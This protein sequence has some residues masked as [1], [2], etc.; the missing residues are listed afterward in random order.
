MTKH[1]ASNVPVAMWG[2]GFYAAGRVGCHHNLKL[3][4]TLR[5]EHNSNPVCQFNCFANFTGDFSTLASVTNANPGSVPYSS[6]IAS[7]LH[8][9]YPGTDTINW[10]PRIGFSW[11]PSS[12]NKTVISGG[13][14]I[15]YDTA[16]AGLV[17][18]LLSNPP[19]AVAIRVRPSTG[20][21]PFDPAGGAATWAASANAFSTSKTYTQIASDLKALGA[22]FAA[23]AVTAIPGT[24][25][26]PSWRSGIS[27]SNGN[28]PIRWS[29][30]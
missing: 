30:T 15:F 9:A 16:P 5:G 14:G 23:P 24:M 20:T 21:L 4:L 7:G 10:S 6:D 13:F 27:R 25:Q 12:S 26:T 11:S 8:Q 2:M 17:D 18:D 28:S 29:S 22:V 3:T 19:V 1:L